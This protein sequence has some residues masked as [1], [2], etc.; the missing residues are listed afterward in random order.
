MKGSVVPMEVRPAADRPE[1]PGTARG[2]DPAA[3]RSLLEASLEGPRVLR[4]EG[5][6]RPDRAGAPAVLAVAAK[7]VVRG[8]PAQRVRSTEERV[9]WAAPGASKR[10]ALARGASSTP[11]AWELPGAQAPS[12]C[13]LVASTDSLAADQAEG[14]GAPE[15]TPTPLLPE[16]RAGALGL[17]LCWG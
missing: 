6:R 5:Q 4:A 10:G 15:E 13:H 11:A 12:L 3:E 7:K 2:A 17:S 8:A 9:P 16:G 14:T 1:V